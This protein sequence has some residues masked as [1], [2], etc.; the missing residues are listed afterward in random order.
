MKTLLVMLVA[1]FSVTTIAIE[2][3]T[4]AQVAARLRAQKVIEVSKYS[5]EPLIDSGSKGGA[6]LTP[7][8]T[9]GH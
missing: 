6:E 3:I 2:F 7:S 5:I 4:E 9:R 8:C 1:V